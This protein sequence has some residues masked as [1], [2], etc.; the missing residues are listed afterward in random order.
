VHRLLF[1]FNL[2]KDIARLPV[3]ILSGVI[4]FDLTAVSH[5]RRNDYLQTLAVSDQQL[6]RAPHSLI[7]SYRQLIPHFSGKGTIHHQPPQK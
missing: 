6:G 7:G 3:G 2:N 4:Q 1:D 5:A